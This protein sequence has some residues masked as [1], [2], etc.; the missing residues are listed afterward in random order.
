MPLAKT[1]SPPPKVNP[2]PQFPVRSSLPWKPVNRRLNTASVGAYLRP[3]VS[4]VF[5]RPDS[6]AFTLVELLAVMGIMVLLLVAI[7]PVVGSIKGG[8]DVIKAAYDISGTLENARTYA[9]ANN[10]YVWVGFFEEDGS[11]SSATP[12]K[13]N[14]TGRVVIYVVASKD[15]TRY[16][17]STDAIN[18]TNP[19]PFGTESP[20]AS[21]LLN[22]VKLVPLLNIIKLDGVHLAGVNNGTKPT[23]GGTPS[24]DTNSP[25]RPG[26]AG[27]FQ[28]G[29]Y[30]SASPN[31]SGHSLPNGGSTNTNP[32]Y[33][34]Y[35][36]TV[37]GSKTTP[38]YTFERIIEFNSQGEASKME[39]NTFGGLGLQGEMEVALQPARGN[40]VDATYS[41]NNAMKA[42]AAIQIEGL[43]G[44]VRM[45]RP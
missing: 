33:F 8:R 11:Q 17:D 31:F 23:A 10:T 22:Q 12:A 18:S 6:A 38:Q 2:Q 28:V 3:S 41:G 37:Y 20:T 32:T 1:P 19:P 29:N 40:V 45:Y 4:S 26:V 36:L 9:I 35:P 27:P 15:G 13:D 44:Q 30:A 42:A 21:K 24:P 34:T 39:E 14:A 5:F 7:V 43:T 16:S 25:V